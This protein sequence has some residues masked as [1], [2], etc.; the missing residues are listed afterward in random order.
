MIPISVPFIRMQMINFL[1]DFSVK[2]SFLQKNHIQPLVRSLN[3]VMSRNRD[4]YSPYSKR[5][6]RHNAACTQIT[7]K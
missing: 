6:Y 1:F 4:S 2:R 7:K 3:T 5:V